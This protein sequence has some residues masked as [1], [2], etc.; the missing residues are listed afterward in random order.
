MVFSPRGCGAGIRAPRSLRAAAHDNCN[1]MRETDL[2]MG[3][4]DRRTQFAGD[5]TLSG[6]AGAADC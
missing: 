6:L 5:L 4:A 3:D 1:Q 2:R